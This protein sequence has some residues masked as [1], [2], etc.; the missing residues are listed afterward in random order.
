MWDSKFKNYLE[1]DLNTANAM[2]LLY[3][4]LKSD[5]ND[6]TKL[7]LIKSWDKVFGL[8]LIKE[9]KELDEEI[10]KKIE[11]RNMAKQNKDFAT[12]DQIRDELLENGIKLI[13]GRD[14][15]TYEYI[16]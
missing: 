16:N 12:A 1:D 13:D 4:L 15:T 2:T 11:E 8:N 6:A 10:L 7:K 5:V 3:D 9:E 14:G